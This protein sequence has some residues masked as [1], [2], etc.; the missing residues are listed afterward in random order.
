MGKHEREEKKLKKRIQI[1]ERKLLLAQRK[2]EATRILE[3]LFDRVAKMKEAELAK[4]LEAEL[5]AERQRK[6][7][8]LKRKKE[9]EEEELAAKKQ[10]EEARLEK[11]EKAMKEALLKQI[12]DRKRAKEAAKTAKEDEVTGKISSQNSENKVQSQ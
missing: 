5:E 6:L 4:K 9:K 10:K 2:L 3:K 1:E 7:D 12:G 11:K 8:R